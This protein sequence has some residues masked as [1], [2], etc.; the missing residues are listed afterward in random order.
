MIDLPVEGKDRGHTRDTALDE[1]NDLHWKDCFRIS[2][3]YNNGIS[4]ALTLD[5]SVGNVSY[6]EWLMKENEIR[7][8]PRRGWGGSRIVGIVRREVNEIE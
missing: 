7:P 8:L 6:L 2:E 3:I 1:D 5:V 4:E